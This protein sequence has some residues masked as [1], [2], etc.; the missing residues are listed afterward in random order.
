MS[1]NHALVDGAVAVVPPDR[2]IVLGA[3]GA[4]IST[5]HDLGRF[6]EMLLGGG[7]IEGRRVLAA[8]TVDEMFSPSMVAAPSFTE[9]PP[10]DDQSGF[11]YGLGWGLYHDRGYQVI[12]KGGALAGIRTVVELVPELK[13]GVAVLANLNV[14]VLPEAIRAFVLERFLGQTD[15]DVQET[16]RQAGA[17][18]R[19]MFQTPTP[20]ADAGP[21]SRPLDAYAGTYANDLYGQVVVVRDGDGL[22]VEAGPARHAN[23]LTP[24]AFDTF[25]LD[26]GTVT[27]I[28][29]PA[30]FTIGPDGTATALDTA[31]FG[32][33]E[34]VDPSS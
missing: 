29:A 1:A 8:G 23:R 2:D 11:A 18:I 7:S 32:R 34:R 6:M 10:I 13:L 17:A 33:L 14:T 21:P 25:L 20:P 26:Q 31:L 12:E 27:T 15:P 5:A 16:I 28:P 3:G 24:Y 9:L 22:R 4:A 19:G 30:T